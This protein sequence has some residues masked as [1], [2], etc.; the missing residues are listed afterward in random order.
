MRI[1]LFVA[2]AALVALTGCTDG[3]VAPVIN[4]QGDT[5]TTFTGAA[6]STCPTANPKTVLIE[7]THD[8][9]VWWFP[10]GKNGFFA[11]SAHQGK[12]F[13]DYLR[14]K[15]YSVVELGRKQAISADS[16][17]KFAVVV[18]AAYYAGSQFPGY[19]ESDL[20]A[21]DA[22]T[23][24]ARTL[25]VLAEY[26]REGE[27]DELV[28]RLGIPLAGSL[29]GTMNSF[30]AHSLT[31]GVDTIRY[32]AGSYLTSESNANIQ[33]LGRVGNQAV[34]G[35][36]AGRQAKIFWVGDTNGIEQMPQPFIDNLLAWGF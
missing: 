30:S 15:G 20:A 31:A 11:D 35:L 10:Q 22:Y 8:G 21:Y 27:H 17:M 2:A 28:D 6:P 25:I 33:V 24:C 34:M 19:T 23:A 36:L 5:V 9:G 26:K 13:A 4:Q 18:R 1:P 3:I 12:P 14:S 7:S 16:M 29:T 32:I